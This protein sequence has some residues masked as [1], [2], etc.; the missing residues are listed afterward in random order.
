L[1]GLILIALP[2]GAPADQLPVLPPYAQAYQPQSVDE[3]GVWMLADEDE[4]RLRDAKVLINDPKLN[5]Y[6]S[7]VLCREVGA[8]RCRGV[9]IYIVR[10]AEFNAFMAPNGMIIV[11]SGLLLRV[12]NE[13]ELAAAIGHEFA[14]FE[15]RH[16]LA[17]YLRRR[18]AGDIIAWTGV[19]AAGAAAYGAY[20]AAK[21]YQSIKIATVGSV[22]AHARGQETE[23]DL[24][25]M[26]YLQSSAY[27]PHCFPD[28][29]TRMMDEADAR[30]RGR[31]QR[32]TR[33]DRVAFLATHPTTLDRTNYLRAIA[34]KLG[35]SGIT[36]EAAY[37][38]ALGRWRAEFLADQIKL[39]DFEGTD[40]LIG[41]IAN[42][43]WTAD[44][45]FA[46]GELYRARGNPRDLVSA[47]EFYRGAIAQNPGGADAY[48][49]LGLA[50]LRNRDPAGASALKTYLAM[51]P[52]AADKS[53]ISML[54]Q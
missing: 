26:A 17:D 49:G 44:L 50:Q 32:S 47:I 7:D 11:N 3:R 12:R 51:R 40:Y 13:A 34:D 1:A 22:Y 41:Q 8:D 37:R 25:S 31:K 18:T 2:S 23:A 46:R 30:A 36:G 16:S 52:D 21:S 15:L 5:Q 29:W 6:V 20:G 9:R 14:H 35:K 27:D 4:R 39:N 54:V 38:E 43:N 24:L 48:R 42:G 45:L 53:M 19:A 28:I 10:D 33:Y